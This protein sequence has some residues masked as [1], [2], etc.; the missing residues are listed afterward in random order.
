LGSE[1]LVQLKNPR[2]LGVVMFLRSFARKACTAEK[3]CSAQQKSGLKP[4]PP[5]V[6]SPIL[7]NFLL[8]SSL[9]VD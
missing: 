4:P 8:A 5:V 6:D 1:N 2:S 9:L 3:I 7:A